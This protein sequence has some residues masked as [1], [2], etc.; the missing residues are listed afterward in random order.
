MKQLKQ[1]ML[2]VAI[3]I[4]F[5]AQAQN[6]DFQQGTVTSYGN[7]T[8]TGVIKPLFKQRGV[9][10]FQ[11]SNAQKK[12]LSPNEISAF[13]VGAEQF[14]AYTNDF[15]KIIVKGEKA[16]LLERVTDNSGKIY[17]N[18]AVPVNT[19]SL[20]GKIGDFYVL[21]NGSSNPVLVSGAAFQ[22]NAATLFSDC[23]SLGSALTVKTVDEA[24][25]KNLVNQYNNCK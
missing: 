4:G 8:S 24:A 19:P 6:S 25:L 5:F 16:S 11:N 22:K 14:S 9:I 13:T 12:Q 18:G 3:L 15:Y 21:K 23:A 1:Q 17:Y 10:I 7:E 2:L 20:D